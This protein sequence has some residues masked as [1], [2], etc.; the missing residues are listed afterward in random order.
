MDVGIFGLPDL[1]KEEI[2]RAV[3]VSIAGA[4]N[5]HGASHELD[6]AHRLPGEEVDIVVPAAGGDIGAVGGDGNR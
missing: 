5:H 4:L 2:K 3:D 6:S 1:L